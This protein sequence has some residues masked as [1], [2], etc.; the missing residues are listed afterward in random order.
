MVRECLIRRAT[1][2]DAKAVHAIAQSAYRHYEQALGIRPAPLTTDYRL[3]IATQDV[4]LAMADAGSIC[5]FVIV[6]IDEHY[7]ID[8]I[9]V[10][11]CHQGF[12]VGRCLLRHAERGAENCGFSSIYL[13]THALMTDNRRWYARQ[14]YIELDR[15]IDSGRDRIFFV[16]RL[17]RPGQVE[18]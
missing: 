11:P 4:W 3:S 7:W 6:D 2:D 14:G 18:C 13:L 8:N 1:S 5:G 15:R 12:G 10:S 17:N 16:K 9:A